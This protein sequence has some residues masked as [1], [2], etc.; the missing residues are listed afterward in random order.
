MLSLLTKKP[1]MAA[2]LLA[3]AAGGPYVL[4]ET[5]AGQSARSY[6]TGSQTTTVNSGW[7]GTGESFVT[8]GTTQDLWNFNLGTPTVDQLQGGQASPDLT[9]PV[10]HDLREV[11]RF[12]ITPCPGCLNV[13]RALVL[14][15]WPICNSTVCARRW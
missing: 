12:D 14:F 5:D 6:L 7:F 9:G 3:S 15:F 13:L 1:A 10:I 2:M 11:L 4:Y 8:G